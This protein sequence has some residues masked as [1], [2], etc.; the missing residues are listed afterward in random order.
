[1]TRE[2]KTKKIHRVAAGMAMALVLVTGLI[3]FTGC[4][5][6][7]TGPIAMAKQIHSMTP[8]GMMMDAVMGNGHG[9]QD[10]GE[11]PHEMGSDIDSQ[12][13]P[14]QSDEHHEQS[15][16]SDPAADMAACSSA[17]SPADMAKES[18]CCP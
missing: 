15:Q 14:T 7:D 11:A 4:A 2:H 16:P 5:S 13:N 1:V 3:A 6:T 18:S 12:P 8:C 9:G 17:D 10:G